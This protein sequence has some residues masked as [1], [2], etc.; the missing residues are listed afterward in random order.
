M[1]VWPTNADARK[2][3]RHPMSGAFRAE[4]HMDWPDDSFTARR[5]ADGDVTAVDPMSQPVPETTVQ[6]IARDLR[7]GR[8]PEKSPSIAETPPLETEYVD[9][10]K[11]PV[12]KPEPKKSKG[13]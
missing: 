7:E 5:I 2:N 8:F 4:G 6:H 9:H 1:K 13:E 3:L 12:K 11:S 10:T